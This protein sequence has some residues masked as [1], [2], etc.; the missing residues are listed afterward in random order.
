M[1]KN[2]VMMNVD[3][4]QTQRSAANRQ[5]NEPKTW[6]GGE[7]AA[8]H[9]MSTTQERQQSWYSDQ[10][11]LWGQK[12]TQNHCEL[13][14]YDGQLH[15]HWPSVPAANAH[16]VASVGKTKNNQF[17]LVW[18]P[19]RSNRWTSCDFA[20]NHSLIYCS[21]PPRC[22]ELPAAPPPRSLGAARWE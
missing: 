22:L 18:L 7:N 19:V 13:L 8:C 12:L 15:S 11:D 1:L 9:N 21:L 4:K 17:N 20:I 2:V 5:H 16:V 10:Q 3:Q 14:G 6:S